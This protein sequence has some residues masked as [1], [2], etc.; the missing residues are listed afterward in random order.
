MYILYGSL[1]KLFEG[2]DISEIIEILTLPYL[3]QF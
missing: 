3:Y 1:F 2:Q